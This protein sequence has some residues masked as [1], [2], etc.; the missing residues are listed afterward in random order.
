MFIVCVCVLYVCPSLWHVML[1]VLC[2]EHIPMFLTGENFHSDEM[3]KK[4]VSFSYNFTQLF[5]VGKIF[6]RLVSDS[7]LVKSCLS[8][9]PHVIL[10]FHSVDPAHS[11]IWPL[12]LHFHGMLS[13]MSEQGAVGFLI[14]HS[15]TMKKNNN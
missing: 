4:T 15:Y 11:G 6:H 7:L 2:S 12:I 8:S 13:D 9:M 3:S 14:S 5:V 1:Y 10:M